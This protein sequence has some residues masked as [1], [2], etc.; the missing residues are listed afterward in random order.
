[1]LSMG[2]NF[3]SST[4]ER[5][6]DQPSLFDQCQSLLFVIQTSLTD[7]LLSVSDPLIQLEMVHD[8]QN[9]VNNNLNIVDPTLI[10]DF[11]SNLNESIIRNLH[12]H[13]FTET[14]VLIRSKKYETTETCIPNEKG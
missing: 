9:H 5:I 11:F 13:Y 10:S 12:V 2:S 6:Y 1:M 14:L 8:A 4:L 7:N 3:L